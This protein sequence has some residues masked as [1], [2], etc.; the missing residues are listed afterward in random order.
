MPVERVS[1]RLPEAC[2]RC[3]RA[4]SVKLEQTI[5]GE[6]VALSWRCGACGDDW[7]VSAKDERRLAERRAG[8]ERRGRFR[9]D[10]RG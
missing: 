1:L 5:T 8:N 3:G 7:P 6:D 10:R 9:G 4:G 2:A